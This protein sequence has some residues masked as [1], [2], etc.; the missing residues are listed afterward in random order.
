MN[1]DLYGALV[2]NATVEIETA[3]SPPVTIR[4][5]DQLQ[6]DSQ[7]PGLFTRL[8]RPRVT[9]RSGETVVFRVEPAGQPD[10]KIQTLA[11]VAIFVLVALGLAS[12]TSR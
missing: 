8:L 4:V 1:I 5:A 10:P 7:G 9:V 11:I 12:I 2:Q 6:G 3:I